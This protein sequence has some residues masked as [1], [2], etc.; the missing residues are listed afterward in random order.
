MIHT[1]AAT[2]F[3]SVSGF[4]NRVCLVCHDTTGTYAKEPKSAGE[5]VAG[6]DLTL[7][8]QNASFTSRQTCGACHFYGG[9][10]DAVKHGDL[11]STMANP[12]RELDVHMGT[13]GGNFSCARC[14]SDTSTSSNKHD[15]IGTRYP[16]TTPDHELCQSC[17]T[18]S[19]H[20]N[21]LTNAKLNTRLNGHT[22]RVSCQACHIPAFARGG[23]TT[24]ESW[25][26]STAGDRNQNGSQKVVT[27]ADGNVVY[28]SMKGTFSWKDKVVPEYRWFNGTV[29][30]ATLDTPITD[31]E[32]LTI[33]ALGGDK[34]DS[35]ARL[36]PVKRFTGRQ[37]YDAGTS[38][39]A[40]PHLFPSSPTDTN[41]YWKG[42]D[43]TN[44]LTSGQA[45]VDRT[46][47]GPMGVVDTEMFW[48]Q[49]HMVAPKEKALACADCH[50]PDSRVDFATLGYPAGEA[51]ALQ[52]FFPI[53]AIALESA[54][55]VAGVTIRWHS[56]VNYFRY[57]VQ[58]SDDLLNWSD[59]PEG[60]F[61]S[62]SVGQEFV[63]SKPGTGELRK[64]YR[65]L[66][67]TQ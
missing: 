5:P 22:D 57:Q 14:H 24:K 48:I 45:S 19:P 46:Y 63:F 41:A 52:S 51:A 21:P 58:S 29:T 40:V 35:T 7:I 6:L 42:Y 33:N 36:F 56:K 54:D 11:D 8:A 59:E 47:V 2:C 23:E 49:N 55:P 43:W 67:T 31:G 37:P 1:Q 15:L 27:D 32:M 66:R 39:L 13:D 28:D 10:G 12:T 61:I 60:K 62:E 9:G 53:E 3:R 4:S 16:T 25:D 30:Y 17:H 34:N 44:A 26:W 20:D 64:F 50:S 65:V 18:A 38:K